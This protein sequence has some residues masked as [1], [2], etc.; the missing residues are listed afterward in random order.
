M[1][2]RFDVRSLVK[3][4]IAVLICQ[5]AGLIGSIFTSGSVST[6]Y[7]TLQKPAFNP[8][9]WVFAPVWTVLYLL[10]GI[11]LFLVWN[12]GIKTKG[13]KTALTFF[14]IQLVLNALWSLFFFGLHFLFFSFIEIIMLWTAILLTIIYFL[15]ISR[16]AGYLLFP[17]ILWVSFAAVLNFSIWMIN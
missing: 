8:P 7:V 17:Y 13:V 1:K 16:I 12:A 10:M 5:S 3:L 4:I 14:G 2:K 11:S 6:W 15:R 9:D